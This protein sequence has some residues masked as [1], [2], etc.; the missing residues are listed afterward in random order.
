M[1]KY[2]ALVK[3]LLPHFSQNSFEKV[4]REENVHA[5]RL[6]KLS[7]R[8]P[9][10]GIWLDSLQEKSINREIYLTY[11]V[12]DWTQPIKDFILHGIH[13]MMI[14]W[15]GKFVPLLLDMFS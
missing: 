5:E 13:Q 10:E 3:Q 6:S 15:L 4:P 12:E 8:E 11:A 1:Q 2:L 7:A 9:M 14:K